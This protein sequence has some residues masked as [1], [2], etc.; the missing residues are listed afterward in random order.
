MTVYHLRDLASNERERI[1]CDDV[2]VFQ[3]PHYKG[4]A[5]EDMLTFAQNYPRVI[6]ALPKDER[7]ILKLHRDYVS[8]VIYTL[9]G[10][11]FSD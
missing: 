8:T 5:I 7:D 2:K 11:P 6:R 10:K 1:H 3:A 4:L 9:V